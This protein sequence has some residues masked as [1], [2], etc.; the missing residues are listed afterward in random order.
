VSP[1]GGFL[2]LMSS[3]AYATYSASVGLIGDARRAATIAAARATTAS[4][5]PSKKL[6]VRL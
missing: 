2:L 3:A 4:K 5:T 6:P 1:I